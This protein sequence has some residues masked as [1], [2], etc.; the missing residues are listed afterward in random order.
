LVA[1]LGFLSLLSCSISL[2]KW[3]YS[4]F[5]RQPRNLEQ[6][7]S[8][9]LVT[10]ATDGIGKAFARQLAQEGLNLILVGRNPTKLDTVSS[11][12]LAEFPDTKVKV[13]LFDFASKVSSS[14]SSATAGVEPIQEATKGLDVGV[15]INNVGITYPSAKFFHEVEENVWMEMVRVNLEGT[16]RVTKAVLPGMVRRRR[17]AIVNV[18]SGA[19]VV[20]PSHPLFTIYAATKA[21]HHCPSLRPPWCSLQKKK[22]TEAPPS[23]III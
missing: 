8:W 21:S 6:Y 14:S 10:G 12:I 9:A 23:S 11:E 22:T 13:V 5:L 16:T 19:A 1:F 18:G 4:T 17:G 7:G 20:V 15:L 3:V 2:L